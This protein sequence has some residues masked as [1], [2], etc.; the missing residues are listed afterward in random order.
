MM[1]TPPHRTETIQGNQCA[2]LR[3]MSRI[4]ST[5]KLHIVRKLLEHLARV[6]LVEQQVG[7]E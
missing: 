4:K 5:F 7:K 3:R 2:S 1:T 6:V